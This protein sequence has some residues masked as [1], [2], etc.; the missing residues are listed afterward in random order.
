MIFLPLLYFG[1][2]PLFTWCCLSP[3]LSASNSD[4]WKV[5]LGCKTS[6]ESWSSFL[7]GK[8][9]RHILLIFLQDSSWWSGSLEEDK[10]SVQTLH[11]LRILST[12]SVVCKSSS[13]VRVFP[14][15]ATGISS[16]PAQLLGFVLTA[17]HSHLLCDCDRYLYKWVY[18]IIQDK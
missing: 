4:M 14:S 9:L 17:S 3:R 10:G 16:S 12:T 13:G 8:V 15:Q 7:L 6:V 18:L 11:L 2:R 1:R 5:H